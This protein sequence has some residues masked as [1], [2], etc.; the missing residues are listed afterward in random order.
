MSADREGL[1]RRL[2]GRLLPEAPDFFALL[3]EQCE[4]TLRA[5][6]LFVD[7]M[8]DGDPEKGR[9]VREAEHAA[10]RVKV[11]NLETLAEAF[12]TPIDREDIHRA[13]VQLDQVVNYCKT[14]VAEMEALEVAPDAHMQAMARLLHEGVAHLAEGFRRLPESPR[15]ASLLA[16]RARKA[17]RR[18][19]EVY[20]RALA[21]L[22]RG[23]DYIGMFKRR[24]LY[25]HLSNAADR[26]EHAADVLQDI[27]VKSG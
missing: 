25:R 3:V 1:L 2:L 5:L 12:I 9:R 11:R 15:Q 17:E 14:T 7:Y 26:L 16:H 4:V 18:V 24:E 6:E 21:E 23:D 20:R 27:V 19:E 13:V 10:D 22:F 8:A